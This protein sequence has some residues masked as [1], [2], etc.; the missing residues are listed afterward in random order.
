MRLLELQLTREC[1][2]CEA[3]GCNV[4][5]QPFLRCLFL[6]G[7]AKKNSCDSLTFI[8]TTFYLAFG[9]HAFCLEVVSLDS[10]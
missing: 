3:A 1:L 4:A 8:H 5:G 9:I 7:C 2:R 10:V 6:V